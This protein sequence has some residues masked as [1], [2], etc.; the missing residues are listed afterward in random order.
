VG[1]HAGMAGY[2]S[3][4]ITGKTSAAQ[5]Q[6]AIDRF[7]NDSSVRVFAGNLIAGGVGITLTS[8]CEVAI[9]EPSWVPG[10]NEQAVDRLHRIG[11]ERKVTVHTLVVEGSLDAKILGAAAGKRFNINEVIGG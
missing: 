11:Q 8:A 5:R 3:V 2:G 10:E 6:N 7:M 4:I 1:L 9:A